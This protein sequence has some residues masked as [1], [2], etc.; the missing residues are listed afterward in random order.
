VLVESS[1]LSERRA[2]GYLTSRE[3]HLEKRSE[4][5]GFPNHKP[6]VD[7]L[8]FQGPLELECPVLHWVSDDLHSEH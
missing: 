1:A 5:A 2:T 7:V 3:V 6:D 4:I 8:G